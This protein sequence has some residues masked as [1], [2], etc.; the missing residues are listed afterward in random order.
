M[1]T[2]AQAM[3]ILFAK[4]GPEWIT[5]LLTLANKPD[6]SLD[7]WVTLLGSVKTYDA[8]VHPETTP[9]AGTSKNPA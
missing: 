6:A 8:I 9:E 7:E 1:P 2:Y 5:Q 4:Y 3:I